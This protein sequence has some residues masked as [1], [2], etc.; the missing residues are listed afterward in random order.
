MNHYDPFQMLVGRVGRVGTGDVSAPQLPWQMVQAPPW[1]WPQGAPIAP[2]LPPP[3]MGYPVGNCGPQWG[4]GAC[5]LPD[6]SPQGPAFYNRAANSAI[7]AQGTQVPL[8]INTRDGGGVGNATAIGAG[9]TRTLTATPVVTYCITAIRVP[10]QVAPFF[11]FGSISAARNEYLM[12]NGQF[13]PCEVYASDT[14]M[15]PSQLPFLNANTPITVLVRNEG[16]QDM[17]FSMSFDGF[18]G[19]SCN[20][21]L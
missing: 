21:C 5:A 15:P 9:L 6:C 16:S 18:P 14:T 10:R 7:S 4:G 13:V 17:H 19:A 8:A 2:A 20:P 3:Q 1:G 11:A 12:N